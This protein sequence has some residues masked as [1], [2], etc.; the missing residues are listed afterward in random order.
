MLSYHP[1]HSIL[2]SH[3]LSKN[4][5]FRI[6]TTVILSAFCMGM[7]EGLSTT[8]T[9]EHRLMVFE[10]KVPSRIFVPKREEVKGSWRQ[11]YEDLRNFLI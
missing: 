6:Y 3:L 2:S 4:L 7:N 8:E 1:L 5:K 10:N 9:E 11:F